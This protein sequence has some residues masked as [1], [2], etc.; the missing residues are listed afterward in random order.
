MKISGFLNTEQASRVCAKAL[1]QDLAV[2]RVEGFIKHDYG[3]EARLDCIWDSKRATHRDA[4]AENNH[5]AAEMI[6]FDNQGCDHFQVSTWSVSDEI[7]Y[8]T[9]RR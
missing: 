6:K 5:L 8:W 7:A 4:I 2:A 1:L 3:Y 9:K